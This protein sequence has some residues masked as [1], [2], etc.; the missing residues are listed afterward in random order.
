MPREHLS[1]VRRGK[2]ESKVLAKRGLSATNIGIK[3]RGGL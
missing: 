2:E 1:I 3:K